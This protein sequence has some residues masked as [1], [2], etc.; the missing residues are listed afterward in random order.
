MLTPS[1]WNRR[2]TQP[3]DS[4]EDATEQSTAYGHFDKLERDGVLAP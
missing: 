4:C 2:R 3:L 1:C